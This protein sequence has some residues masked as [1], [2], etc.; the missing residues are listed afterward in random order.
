MNGAQ[1]LISTLVDGGVDVCFA[2]PG[3]SEMHFVAALDAVPRDARRAGAVRGRGHRRRRRLRADGRA[4]PP[5]CCCIWVRAWAT[6][7]PTCTTRAAPMC[8]WWSSSAITPPTTRSTT[9]HWNPTSTR[10]PARVSGWVRRTADTAD[11]AADA[12]DAITASRT[13]SVS[14][15]ILP[16]DVSWTD[17]AQPARR[18]GPARRAR[19]RRR[20]G[21][22]GGRGAALR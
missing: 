7:W 21:A 11:V 13:G 12:A 9:P 6:A 10:W 2:N 1:A 20:C 18:S 14:T 4:N 8:R 19:G 16:A 17:G 3:T 15:L 5:R 22:R